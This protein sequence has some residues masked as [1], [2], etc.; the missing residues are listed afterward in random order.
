MLM[1]WLIGS[2]AWYPVVFHMHRRYHDKV[3]WTIYAPE[4]YSK[5]S[6]SSWTIRIIFMLFKDSIHQV[7]AGQ[8]S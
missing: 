7:G 2:N 5:A 4:S 1:C 6:N 8:D 3:S